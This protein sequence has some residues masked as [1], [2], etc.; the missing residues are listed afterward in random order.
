MMDSRKI[1]E[2][3]ILSLVADFKFSV[4]QVISRDEGQY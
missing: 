1:R 3:I 4:K 2:A